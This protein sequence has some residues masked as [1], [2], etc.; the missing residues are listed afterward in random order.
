MAQKPTNLFITGA[1]GYVGGM[2]A[3]QFSKRDDVGVVV[4]LDKEAKPDLLSN[5]SKIIWIRDNTSCETW[6]DAVANYEPSVVIHAAWQIREMYGRRA[7]QWQWNVGGAQKVFDFAFSHSFVGRLIHFSSASCYGA[8]A[9]NTLERWFGENEDLREDEYLY[10]VEK[11]AAEKALEKTFRAAKKEGRE[12]PQVTVVRPAAITGPRGRFMFARF[13]LQSVLRKGLPI[14]PVANTIWCRQFIHEDD[15]SDIVSMLTFGEAHHAYEV[16]NITP[17]TTVLAHDMA[18]IMHKRTFRIT[19]WMVRL[20]FFW[21]WHG[22]RGRIPTSRGGWKFYSYPIVMDGSKI[23][24]MLGYRYQ[25]ESR[26][27]LEKIEGRYK[28]YAPLF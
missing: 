7:L 17:N 12:T 19:P 8:L 15:V 13:G 9:S 4:C 25:F 22:S 18:D 23:T 11:I 20:A 6:Q 2:L 16:F 27:A 24:T 14:I 1:A 10:G 3:D 26:P 21:L 28:K 5:N